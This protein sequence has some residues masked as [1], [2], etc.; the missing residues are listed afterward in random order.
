VKHNKERTIR[1]RELDHKSR[2]ESK[3]IQELFFESYSIEAQ[4][5]G[6]DDFPPLRR[7]STDICRAG[8]VFYGAFFGDELIAAAEIEQSDNKITNIAG[9]AVR[10]DEIRRGIGSEFLLFLIRSIRQTII[11]VSTAEKNIPA[12]SLYQK[13][14]FQLSKNWETPDGIKMLT[15]QRP[16]DE[17]IVVK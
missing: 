6:V 9:F 2:L 17:E 5:I 11:S 14:G 12:I 1:F 8:S 13:H 10:P 7:T 15:F 3:R 4:L 16:L